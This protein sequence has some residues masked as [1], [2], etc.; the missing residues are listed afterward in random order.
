MDA[1]LTPGVPEVLAALDRAAVAQAEAAALI[2]E[3]FGPDG[4]R[5]RDA[6]QGRG[7][8][9]VTS[10]YEPDED[11]GDGTWNVQAPDDLPGL[12]SVAG[13]GGVPGSG[14][15][16]VGDLLTV[17]GRVNA[18]NA[19]ADQVR[20]VC[21]ELI[22]TGSDAFI[23]KPER[24]CD[25]LGE[26]SPEAAVKKYL[27]VSKAQL[28]HVKSVRAG[29]GGENLPL[30]AH[31]PLLPV[32]A[33][34]TSGAAITLEQAEAIATSL[35][36]VARRKT[37]VDPD[38]LA[39]AEAT[40]VGHATGGR[41]GIPP[42]T[43]P[44][45]DLIAG[46]YGLGMHPEELGRLAKQLAELVDQ[47]G[48]E[49]D[50]DRV[51]SQ[52]GLTLKPGRRPGDPATL[53]AK[54]TQEAYEQ[55]TVL[56]ASILDPKTGVGP[57][58]EVPTDPTGS[59]LMSPTDAADPTAAGSTGAAGASASGESP[60]TDPNP[61][62]PFLVEQADGVFRF[63]DEDPITFPQ[64]QH[65]A[66]VTL[67]DLAAKTA[68]DQGGA[69]PRVILL[70]RAEQVLKA[71]NHTP[72]ADSEV[73]ATVTTVIRSLADAGKAGYL[74]DEA[75]RVINELISL[76]ND[77]RV[78]R[79]DDPTG[80]LSQNSWTG[81]N[82]GPAQ[83]GAAGEAAGLPATGN[84]KCDL[85]APAFGGS[86]LQDPRLLTSAVLPATGETIPLSRLG[87]I[88][89]T[90]ITEIVTT[91]GG[92]FL[93][94]SVAQHRTFTA[95]QRRALLTTYVT[96]AVPDCHVPGLRCDAHHIQPASLAGPTTMSNGILLCRHHHRKLHQGQLRLTPRQP[97]IPGFNATPP[98]RT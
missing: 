80:T 28:H 92:E 88:L 38:A 91:K 68:P 78:L 96:C 1:G 86:L 56:L 42:D 29:T 77:N 71:L 37:G 49:P 85:P 36:P 8:I 95:A 66:F 17:L 98:Q 90:A 93:S 19:G 82:R 20:G 83:P 27:L 2:E 62:L 58:G 63:P 16:S 65:D 75:I 7:G 9:G 84:E 25:L 34:A 48:P 21:A 50:D 79:D 87:V 74:T 72:A 12:Q 30:A 24:I 18:V 22:L 39:T 46:R 41:Y 70:A 4:A 89:C 55:L 31:P 23:P 54:L 81:G 33:E 6:I 53:N 44:V 67:L 11:G 57:S 43:V 14:L 61:L 52:R 69:P 45:T 51:H 76:L 13:A 15:V 59:G 64:A 26:R 10:Y 5:V 32:L 35:I 73:D 47:D 94:Y 60:E 97:A 40:L 3:V